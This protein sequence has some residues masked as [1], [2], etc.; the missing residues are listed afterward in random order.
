MADTP[1]R[2]NEMATISPSEGGW[3]QSERLTC[4][5]IQET[6]E[7]VLTTQ[8]SARSEKAMSSYRMHST[9][10]GSSLLVADE[11]T[12]ISLGCTHYVR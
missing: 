6:T 4:T 8:Q 5:I 11:R 7:H 2:R 12:A 10:Y 9:T 3:F 1:G